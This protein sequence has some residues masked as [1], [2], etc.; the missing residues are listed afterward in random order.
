[1]KTILITF[2]LL[3]FFTMSNIEDFMESINY[4][5]VDV[6]RNLWLLRDLDLKEQKAFETLQE[7]LTSI[8]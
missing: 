7:Y 2:L 8:Y 6:R 1:M 5:P 3:F 4:S